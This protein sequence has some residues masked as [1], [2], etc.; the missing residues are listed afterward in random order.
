[1]RGFF[2]LGTHL[3]CAETV[4]FILLAYPATN[5]HCAMLKYCVVFLVFTYFTSSFLYCLYNLNDNLLW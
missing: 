5:D 3:Q 1:M 4:T 2:Y